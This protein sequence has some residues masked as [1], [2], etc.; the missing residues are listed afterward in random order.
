M[1][2]LSGLF[3]APKIE[4]TPEKQA[5][6]DE[7]CKALSLYQYDSCPFCMRV[8]HNIARLGLN[9]ELKDTMREPLNER[10][11]VV[12]G[13]SDMVPCLRIAE[14]DD[15]VIWLYESTDIVNYLESRFG[16]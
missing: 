14:A 9:I 5:E 16:E 8:R 13:G 15:N 1:S 3:S 6:V 7:A 2:F 12:E 11:L 4:R 10:D